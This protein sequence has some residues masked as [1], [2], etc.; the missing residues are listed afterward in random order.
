[1]NGFG[2][3]G[4]ALAALAMAAGLAGCGASEAERHEASQAWERCFRQVGQEVVDRPDA[5][6]LSADE[7]KR[8]I[9][10]AAAEECG[11]VPGE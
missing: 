10:R 2:R 9:V 3:A 11:E 7:L 5:T 4:V 8:E 6:G 1:M